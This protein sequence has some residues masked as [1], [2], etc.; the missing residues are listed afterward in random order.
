[1]A[2]V[3]E[4]YYP[5]HGFI[6]RTITATIVLTVK[7]LHKKHAYQKFRHIPSPISCQRG[8]QPEKSLEHWTS[9]WKNGLPTPTHYPSVGTTPYL[10]L[11]TK[12]FRRCDNGMLI[13]ILRTHSV[14]W[15]EIYLNQPVLEGCWCWP[16]PLPEVGHVNKGCDNHLT[17]NDCTLALHLLAAADL[18]D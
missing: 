14:L 2:T 9:T 6:W 16:R 3:Y 15:Q 8:R 11:P 4:R 17:N 5:L 10:A 12:R 7:K 13:P 1:M 18:I